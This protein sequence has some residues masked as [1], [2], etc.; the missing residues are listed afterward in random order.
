MRILSA[1]LLLAVLGGLAAFLT[2]SSSWGT[3]LMPQTR[4]ESAELAAAGEPASPTPD[5]A[6]QTHSR[7]PAASRAACGAGAFGAVGWDAQA[8]RQGGFDSVRRR[9]L[10]VSNRG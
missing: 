10:V 1:F 3:L 2:F 8:W 6:G 9:S 7:R 4:A 5:W